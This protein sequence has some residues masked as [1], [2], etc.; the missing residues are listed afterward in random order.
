MEETRHWILQYCSANG[1]PEHHYLSRWCPS[2]SVSLF[3]CSLY[4]YIVGFFIDFNLIIKR[5]VSTVVVCPPNPVD[6][7]APQQQYA[8]YAPQAYPPQQGYP[9]PQYPT[10]QPQ[11][12]QY[13]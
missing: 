5:F 4:F 6:T 8:P 10:Q 12:S 7:Y 2:S 13:I 9:A 3:N 1:G 11:Q